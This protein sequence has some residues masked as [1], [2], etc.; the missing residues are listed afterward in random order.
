MLL[1][2]FVF[3]VFGLV[4]VC[5]VINSVDKDCAW[6]FVIIFGLIISLW[7]II[8][9][10]NNIRNAINILNDNYVIVLDELDRKE[11][12]SGCDNIT[13]SRW[14]LFFKDYSSKYNKYIK[15]SRAKKFQKGDKFYLIF[16]KGK[17]IPSAYPVD[18]YKLA[19][20]EES[21]LKKLDEVNN[22]KK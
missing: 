17:R 10:I 5:S 18:K 8:V 19:K 6:I 9:I 3:V 16:I 4:I 12:H 21:K 20:S 22:Y 14:K 2:F 13:L 7:P 15:Y 1:F 11:Y